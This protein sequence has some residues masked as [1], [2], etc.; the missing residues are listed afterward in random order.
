[1][2]RTRPI[3]TPPANP[4]E[5]DILAR[6]RPDPNRPG[7]DRWRLV[8][9]ERPIWAIIMHMMAFL[10]VDDPTRASNDQIAQ[11]ADAY[12]ISDK[13]VRAAIAYYAAN[14]RAIDTIIATN[15]YLDLGACQVPARAGQ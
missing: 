10:G 3:S 7:P 6:V 13:A 14:R 12:C 4:T 5:I 2:V 11:T 15:S 1:M 8:G 9:C